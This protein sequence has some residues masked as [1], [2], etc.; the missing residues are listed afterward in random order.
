MVARMHVR[1][2]SPMQRRYRQA[3]IIEARAIFPA[4]HEDHQLRTIP[5][6]IGSP[7]SIFVHDASWTVSG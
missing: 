2:R 6:T 1:I 4:A 3:T 7:C 5:M